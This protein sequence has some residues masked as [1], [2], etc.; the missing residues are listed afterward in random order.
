MKKTPQIF[1]TVLL[2]IIVVF[3]LVSVS[4]FLSNVHVSGNGLLF[5]IGCAVVGIGIWFCSAYIF[6]NS[7]EL[8]KRKK[9]EESNFIFKFPKKPVPYWGTQDSV[10]ADLV[11]DYDL[12]DCEVERIVDSGIH[13]AVAQYRKEH[14]LGKVPS[15]DL[16]DTVFPYE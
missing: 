5:K 15:E 10:L 8:S 13:D 4:E 6:M 1:R 2:C 9:E 12:N 7:K 11:Y 3:L 14:P 16:F